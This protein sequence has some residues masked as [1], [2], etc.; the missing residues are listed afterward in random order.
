LCGALKDWGVRVAA[1]DPAEWAS[2]KTAAKI[3]HGDRELSAADVDAL[4]EDAY[5]PGYKLRNKNL[6][7][8]FDE[9]DAWWFDNVRASA[10]KLSNEAA[11]AQCFSLGLMVG[12]YARSFDALTRV[13]RQPLSKVFRRLWETQTARARARNQQRCSSTHGEARA[14]IAGQHNVDLLFLR[15]PRAR[16]PYGANSGQAFDEWREEWIRAAGDSQHA[17]EEQNGAR[18][19]A[20]LESKNQYL[21]RVEELLQTALHIG[22]WAIAHTEDSFVSTAELVEIINQLRKV[23][24]IYTKDFSELMGVR[25]TI[26]TA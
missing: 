25:A 23:E 12:D 11:R 17:V 21:R 2:I 7:K 10:E 20:T 4:L 5:V 24:T 8:W 26:I 14:F 15:L 9:S 16:N 22:T 1:N 18:S 19:G 13:L 6:R 3:Q